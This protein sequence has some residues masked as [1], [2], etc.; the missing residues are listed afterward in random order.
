MRRGQPMTLIRDIIESAVMPSALMLYLLIVFPAYA[1]SKQELIAGGYTTSFVDA[2]FRFG[3]A[4][5]I[6]VAIWWIL[7]RF[8]QRS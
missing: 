3:F 7:Q 8:W 1:L 5:F 2:A 6:G 4:F